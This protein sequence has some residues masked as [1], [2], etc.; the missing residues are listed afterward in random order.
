MRLLI[1][2]SPSKVPYLQRYLDELYGRRSFKV[3]STVGHWRG[4]PAM[5][6]IKLADAV[7]LT[8]WAEH[9][10]VHPDKSRVAADLKANIAEADEVLLA[11]DADREGEAIA[12]HV[13][14]VFRPKVVKRVVYQEV[15][16]KA[17]KAAVERPRAIDFNLVEA[18]RTRQV[19]DYAIGMEVSRRLWRFGCRSAGRVQS[20]GLRILVDRETAIS[21][22]KAAPFWTVSATYVEGF[23]A[24]VAVFGAPSDEELDDSGQSKED[25]T[26]LQPKR[27]TSQTEADALVAEGRSV[28]HVIERLERAPLLRR[29]KPPF[30]TTGLYAEA[31]TA[32]DWP[33]DHTAKLAQGLFE[34]GHI[35]YIRTD[36][37]ALSDD[38]I[39]DVR[40]YL[41]AHH[42]SVLPLE[43]QRY[44]DK[45]N[46]QG[47]HEAIR[48]VSMSSDA[49]KTLVGDEKQLY[50][51]IWS[52]TLQCQ[53]ASAL[54]DATTVT[55]RPGSLSWRLLA[56]GSVL[57]E[58]GFLSLA[59]VA[60]ADAS[61]VLPLLA[62]GQALKL[63]ELAAKSSHTK[64][65]PRFTLASFTRYLERKG[66]GRPSTTDKIYA[67]LLERTYVKKA[68]K[69]I[70]PD[71]SGFLC[72]RLTRVSF[73]T[74]TQERFTAV[75]EAALDKI[76]A[77][78]LDRAAFLTNFYRQ[79]AGM[80]TTADAHLA[81]YAKRHP[82]LDRD[83]AIPHDAPCRACGAA[84]IRRRGKFG[85][86]AQCTAEACGERLSL[87]PLK[88]LKDPCPTCGGVVVEQPHMKDGKRQVYYRCGNG[89]W[90]SSLKPPKR[91]KTRCHV[92]G[93]HGGMLEVTGKNRETG[94]TYKRYACTTCDYSSRV[95]DVPP[96]CPLCQSLTTYFVNR[97]TN[98]PF[99]GCSQFRAT[100]CRGAVKYAAV[101]PP[102]KKQRTRKA[103]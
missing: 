64:P 51:L 96:P 15:T 88:E 61:P 62:E 31:S 70:V 77:G 103:S 66:I 22:F 18:Q 4:L 52:R 34:A 94:E 90:S 79:F 65:L 63:R 45:A 1:V 41:A 20:A 57:R 39:A 84:M 72:D 69:H 2:E 67:T 83:S 85:S 101:A 8:T 89:D 43:T 73:D 46:A 5:T 74:L 35:T 68:G 54:F 10:V 27:F 97:Q 56:R 3:T 32:F 40:G 6:N 19:L 55:I 71:E 28:Q 98:E 11:T 86:Y 7:D 59:G 44:V 9:F 48:P 50:D 82:E 30:T 26:S 60:D 93:S 24:G 47:A 42:P 95:V 53:A 17:L 14:S 12:W 102:E 38:A 16:K 91:T 33:P 76:A 58:P 81:D 100:G 21:D 80:L 92:D 36:S 23:S 78:K 87:E 25:A 99:W 75:T 37:V 29:P 13:L 49:S